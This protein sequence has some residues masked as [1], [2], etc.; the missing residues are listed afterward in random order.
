[1]TEKRSRFPRLPAGFP[2]TRLAIAVAALILVPAFDSMAGVGLY[3]FFAKGS[4]LVWTVLFLLPAQIKGQRLYKALRKIIFALVSLAVFASAVFG[5][6]LIPY[7][8]SK[9]RPY[10]VTPLWLIGWALF[11]AAA[12]IRKRIGKIL[13][14]A[15]AFAQSLTGQLTGDILK[16]HRL[17]PQEAASIQQVSWVEPILMS[18]P[19]MPDGN[20]RANRIGVLSGRMRRMVADAEEHYLFV[21]CSDPFADKVPLLRIDLSDPS[22]IDSLMLPSQEGLA[23]DRLGA[24]LLAAAKWDKSVLAIDPVEMK[25]IARWKQQDVSF[26]FLQTNSSDSILFAAEEGEKICA[27]SLP[28]GE[29]LGCGSLGAPSG[30]KW[31]NVLFHPGAVNEMEFCR[32]ADRLLVS[33]AWAPYHIRSVNPQSLKVETGRAFPLGRGIALADDSGAI[34]LTDTWLGRLVLVKCDGF[35]SL[36]VVRDTAGVT[37]AAQDTNRGLLYTGNY[38]SGEFCIRDLKS[39]SLSASVKLGPRYR[40]ILLTK[41]GR[42]FCTTAYGLYEIFPDRLGLSHRA[43]R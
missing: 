5:L 42:V 40:Q 6:F 27:F 28:N 15:G 33:T 29:Q 20:Q 8:V 12:L 18:H 3:K 32:S 25:A 41:R 30:V 39:G 36:R 11:L 35:D 2:S 14:I 13:L 37:V 24:K 34:W 22:R 7:L 19:F 23:F 31:L 38:F 9:M 21:S 17:H 4:L 43:I 1:M 16:G 26:M 10:Q